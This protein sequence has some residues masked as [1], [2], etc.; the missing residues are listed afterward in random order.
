MARTTYIHAIL[1]RSFREYVK[2]RPKQL[3]PIT[4]YAGRREMILATLRNKSTRS[5]R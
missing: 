2:I 5:I 3:T 1:A 4:F